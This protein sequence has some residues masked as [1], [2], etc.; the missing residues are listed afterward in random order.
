[1]YGYMYTDVSAVCHSFFK[2]SFDMS[3]AAFLVFNK[4]NVKH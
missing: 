2:S 1:M 4:V 3:P